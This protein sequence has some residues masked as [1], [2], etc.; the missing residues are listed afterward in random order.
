MSDAMNR[1]RLLSAAGILLPNLL[2]GVPSAFAAGVKKRV[3]VIGAGISGIT[4]AKALVASG[5]DVVVLE[6]RN[7]IGG[8]IATSTVWSDTP[9]DLGASWIHGQQGNPITAIAKTIRAPMATTLSD[10]QIIYG[11][12]GKVLD[13]AAASRLETLRTA[14]EKTVSSAQNNLRADVSLQAAIEAGMRWSQR[15]VADQVAM[16]Y[17]IN[18]DYEQEYGG[19]S[20]AMSAMWFDSGSEFPGDDLLFLTGYK[21]ISD[22]LAKGLTIQLGEIVR[23]IKVTGGVVYVTTQSKTFAADKVLV[24]LPLGVLKSGAIEFLPALPK[25][26]INAISSLGMGLLN[27]C[28][29][30]FERTFWAQQYDWLG[31][32]PSVPGRWAEWISLSRHVG[33]PI[34]VGF[35]AAN[36]GREIE[37]WTDNQI[38]S[39]AMETLRRIYGPGIPSPIG[40]QI[41]RWASDPFAYGAYSFLPVGATPKL[42]ADLAANVGQ[43]IFFAGE[44]THRQ[45]PAT[46]HGAYLSGVR[47]AG[48]IQSSP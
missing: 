33:K 16:R 1:R 21:A 10:S 13:A 23:R 43:T 32:I 20:A 4:A 7:R 24:T 14:I 47:A 3:I 9:V 25:A 44:A 11:E 36:F 34:L 2:G 39:S 35:N 26:K 15:P 31:Y 48:E 42:R 12:N 41:T 27:K 46:V 8:R 5:H 38:V 22:Y 18:S 37:Q 28:I 45:Y 40:Y 19:S 6:A 29:L 30:R 17:L